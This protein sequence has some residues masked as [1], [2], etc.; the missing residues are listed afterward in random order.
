MAEG[1]GD[2]PSAKEVSEAIAAKP[3]EELPTVIVVLGMAGSGKTSLVQRLISHLH[4]KSKLPYVMNLDPACIGLLPYPCNIDVRDTVN[5]KEV[6]KQYGLGP[7]GGIVTSLNMFA[8][9]FDQVSIQESPSSVSCINYR[10][11]DRN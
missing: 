6:M 8:T 11:E 2:G 1:G 9:K 5:Y 4:M 7:N 3:K 10:C